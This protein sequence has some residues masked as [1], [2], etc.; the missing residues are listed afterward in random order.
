MPASS[1]KPEADVVLGW[2]SSGAVTAPAFE[3][4]TKFVQLPTPDGQKYD[5]MLASIAQS[6]GMTNTPLA[7]VLKKYA[8]DVRPARV[9][10][11]GFSEGCQ[12]VRSMLRSKDAR[13]VDSVIAIDGIH[14]QF[15]EGS[16]TTLNPGYLTAWSAFAALAADGERLM[17]DT[18]S[19][20]V[21]PYPYVSTTDTS[22]WIW[23]E[24]T[25]S[26]EPRYDHALP[27]ALIDYFQPPITLK[28]GS[29]GTLV[30]PEVTYELPPLTRYRNKGGLWVFNYNDL[31]PTGHQD[32]VLQAQAI[33]PLMLTTFLA[34][35]WNKIAPGDGICVL[36]A[37][38]DIVDSAP[39]PVGCFFPTRLTDA[40]LT[41]D[42]EPAPLDINV[43]ADP[44][45]PDPN[46]E[47][48]HEAPPPAVDSAADGGDTAMK[49][50]KWLGGLFAG[51]VVLEGARRAG[52]YIA[53]HPATAKITKP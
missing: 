43:H 49:V 30:W 11:L 10:L 5:D 22:N 9:A 21:P 44:T 36:A 15:Q 8:P 16:H 39:P 13:R 48:S 12:G 37:G 19:A 32:H 46:A 25:G 45:I 26:E 27:Q 35:R 29:K 4:P 2:F 31:D 24:A 47:P 6:M 34:T 40:F 18:T 42:A 1:N 7:A 53:E 3:R 14:A 28:G 38:E 20:I 52:R 41:G 23:R 51:A 17:I 33:L 50:L